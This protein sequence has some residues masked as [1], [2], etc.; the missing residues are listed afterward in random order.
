VSLWYGQ[1]ASPGGGSETVP[2]SWRST[3]A[4]APILTAVRRIGKLGVVAA[5]V[6]AGTASAA[7]PRQGVL[8]PGRSLGGV[9]LGM[10]LDQ[11]REAWHARGAACRSCARTTWY[12]NLRAFEPQGAAVELRRGR[13]VAVFT[14]WKPPGWRT[15]EGL[16]LGETV[17]RV[18]EVYGALAR[19]E[20]GRH[21]ALTLRRGGALTAFYVLDERLW[22]FALSR[23]DVPVCR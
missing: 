12:F 19:T 22:G 2:P 5:L 4:T 18:T 8:V 23:P 3:R 7:P 11:V 1:I 9:S 14:V 17:P 16:V 15:R 10:T 21:Y 20:C 13:V 6:L